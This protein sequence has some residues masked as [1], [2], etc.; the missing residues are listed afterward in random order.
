MLTSIVGM[1]RL[2]AAHVPPAISM[3]RLPIT[4]LTFHVGLRAAA[5]LPHAHGKCRVD[6]AGDDSSRLAR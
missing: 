1:D 3:A 4:S 6:L 5:G 2:L